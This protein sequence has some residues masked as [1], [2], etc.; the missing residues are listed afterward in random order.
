MIF[1]LEL[2]EDL[3][4]R[5]PDPYGQA[6]TFQRIQITSSTD[7]IDRETKEFC[8]MIRKCIAFRKKWMK[9]M[10]L[11][12]PS[13]KIIDDNDDNDET[14]PISPR[15]S[16]KLRH[17]DEIPYDPFEKSIPETTDHIIKMVDGVVNV[18]EVN[19]EKQEP[20]YRV[21]TLKEYYED[22]FEIKRI[23]NYGPVKVSNFFS[24]TYL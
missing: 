5:I 13:N 3:F 21:G 17:R 4:E 11:A 20:Q 14:I 16:G 18:F 2:V 15:Q 1:R 22:L 8:E 7:E 23:I 10:E 19:K 12:V 9:V 24:V 6:S